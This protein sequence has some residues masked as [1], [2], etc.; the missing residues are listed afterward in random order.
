MFTVNAICTNIAED[1]Y[2]KTISYWAIGDF[3]YLEI[4]GEIKHICWQN[5]KGILFIFCPCWKWPRMWLQLI[6]DSPAPALNFS[7]APVFSP[8]NPRPVSHSPSCVLSC[9][10][11]L[12]EPSS[13]QWVITSQ[14]LIRPRFSYNANWNIEHYSIQ[15]YIERVLFE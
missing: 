1:W 9:S 8:P 2:H 10:V 14:C 13:A 11:P 5:K 4:A 3:V 12:S 7:K 15:L 6:W